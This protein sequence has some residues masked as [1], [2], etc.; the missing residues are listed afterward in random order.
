MFVKVVVREV[1]GEVWRAR[2]EGFTMEGLRVLSG[3]TLQKIFGAA[4]GDQ[5]G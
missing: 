1:R 3:E 2:V 5:V 4:P